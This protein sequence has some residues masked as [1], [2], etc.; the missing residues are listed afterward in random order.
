MSVLGG[1]QTDLLD[2]DRHR[3]RELAQAGLLQEVCEKEI[4]RLSQGLKVAE[5]LCVLEYAWDRAP[6]PSLGS[7]PDY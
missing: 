1:L 5:G 4:T 7:Q 3:V 6:Q 2:G